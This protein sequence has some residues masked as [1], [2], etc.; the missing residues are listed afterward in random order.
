MTVNEPTLPDP[1]GPTS[2]TSAGS[3]TAAPG[4]GSVGSV[5]LT[6]VTD[7]H[8]ACVPAAYRLPGLR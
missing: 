3:G 4:S 8:H 2:T 6:R 5:T 1:A 7:G